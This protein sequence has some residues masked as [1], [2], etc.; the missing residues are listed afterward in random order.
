VTFLY[1]AEPVRGAAWARIFAERLPD[2]PFRIWPDIGRPEEIR[3]MAAWMP[4]E[5]FT[6]FPNLEILFSVAAGVDQLDL[7]AI[8]PHLPLVRMI[9]P[10]LEAGMVEFATMAVLALHRGMPLYLGRQRE[11]V[12]EAERVKLAAETR[13]G[14]MGLGVLGRAVLDRLATFGFPL[15]GWSRSPRDIPGVACHAGLVSLPEFLAGCDILICLL[16]LTVETRGI[17]DARLFAALPSGAG[18]VNLGRGGHLVA[19][20]LLAWLARDPLSAA[21]LDVTE[22]EPLPADHPFWLHPRIWLTPHI[23]STTRA[24]SGADAIIA[25]LERWMR[26]ETP[27][28]LIDRARGY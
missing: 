3:Y 5:D 6:Q 27:L 24:D 14:V 20:D 22:P 28:G 4:P 19:E 13:V 7:P 17:L 25:N 11:A 8:P 26:G 21:I 12:W 9:E 10:G 2:M 1:K 15:A 18:V 23:A 16:P